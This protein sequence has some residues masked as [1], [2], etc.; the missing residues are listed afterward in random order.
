[1]TRKQEIQRREIELAKNAAE[2]WRLR[3]PFVARTKQDLEA[4]GPIQADSTARVR[5]FMRRERNRAVLLARRR[6]VDGIGFEARFGDTLDYEYLPPVAEADRA[7]NPVA[8]LIDQGEAEPEGF[9]TG[10][11]I[12][13]HLLLTNYHVFPTRE[14]ARGVAAQFDYERDVRRGTVRRGQ[15]FT[16]DPTR[17]FVSHRALDYAIVAIDAENEA[18]AAT[19]D[20]KPFPPLIGSVGKILKGH[21]VNIIH[22]PGGEPKIYVHKNNKLV[23]LDDTHLRY[24]TDTD[25]GSSGSPAFNSFWELIALH[26]RSVPATFLDGRIR[27]VG[28]EVWHEEMGLEKVKWVANEGIRISALVA[29]LRTLKFSSRAEQALLNQVLA[30]S[31]DPL[32]DETLRQATS[33]ASVM[34]LKE[35]STEGVQIHVHGPATF[36]IGRGVKEGTPLAAPADE[37]GFEAV[38]RFDSRY[39]ERGGYDPAFL[40]DEIPVPP[41]STKEARLPEIVR[42]TDGTELVLN[43]H[44]YSLAMNRARRLMM[45]SAVN[46]DYDPE[47]RKWFKNRKAFGNDKWISDPRIPNSVQLLD[48][49][50][51][52]PSPSLQ[53][54]HIVRRE[55]CAWGESKRDQEYANSDTFH[56]TNCTPQHGGFNEATYDSEEGT[57]YGIWGG[58]E[59]KITE[60]IDEV[61]QQA[62][63]LAGPVLDSEYR[64][65]NW[66]LGPVLVPLRYWKIVCVKE[67]ERLAAYGF[68]LDQSQAIEDLGLERRRLDFGKFKA[69]QK[70]VAH[71][72]KITDVQFDRAV[73]D[74]DVLRG[75][76]EGY[77]VR[78][79]I[80]RRRDR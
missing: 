77:E 24:L 43:Y 59:N 66:G 40:G 27:A 46:V 53:R 63:I 33:E 18:G 8:R 58:L 41:P 60:L 3:Q 2:E 73:L 14:D 11:L 80:R 22:H 62:C 38:I 9:A 51:Y 71:I 23:D 74:A 20:Y 17:F 65:K 21:P 47:K 57:Y 12:S 42:D 64:R 69:F 4:G 19:A 52:G 36:N 32:G 37:M 72:S 16:L 49:Q 35:L 55:D 34:D 13:P 68:V 45:W 26:H 48:A 78:G 15:I 6:S 75:N 50:A 56:W 28:G 76:D 1:M 44:H 79:E 39:E 31:R 70:S 25:P 30:E 67:Q 61:G 29:H 7:G 10:F 54:G 5:A